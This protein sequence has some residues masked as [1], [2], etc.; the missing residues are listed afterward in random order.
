MLGEDFES[1]H[2]PSKYRVA[3]Q[4]ARPIFQANLQAQRRSL[5]RKSLAGV[6]VTIDAAVEGLYVIGYTPR[7]IYLACKCKRGS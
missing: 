7:N 5:K 3:P 2:L 6:F 1:L 4:T